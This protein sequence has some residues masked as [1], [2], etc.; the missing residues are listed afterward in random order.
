VGNNLPTAEQ[1]VGKP[2][3]EN[4]KTGIKENIHEIKNSV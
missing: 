1:I 3:E 2:S 4:G